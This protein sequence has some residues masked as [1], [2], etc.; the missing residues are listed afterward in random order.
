MLIRT[1][2]FA[3]NGEL[4]SRGIVGAALRGR[5][6]FKRKSKVI[7]TKGGHRGPPLQY[8]PT[9]YFNEGTRGDEEDPT[10]TDPVQDWF[11][12]PADE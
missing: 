5:P 12:I 4:A 10:G 2:V 6:R 11:L 8:V 1:R 7:S 3:G 9:S